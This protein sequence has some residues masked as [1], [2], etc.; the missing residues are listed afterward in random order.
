ML[1]IVQMPI[2]G[3]YSCLILHPKSQKMRQ[4]HNTLNIFIKLAPPGYFIVIITQICMY[5]K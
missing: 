1:Y 4:L 5:R 2:F 3:L